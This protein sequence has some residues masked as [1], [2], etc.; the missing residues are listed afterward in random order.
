MGQLR[1]FVSH[2]HG[3]QSF[4]EALVQALRAAGA[5]VWYDQHNLGPGR[6]LRDINREIRDRPIFLVV[7]SQAALASMWVQR[8]EGHQGEEAEQGWGRAGDRAVGPLALSS[9]HP[10]AHAPRGTSPRAASAT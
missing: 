9:P 1:I 6:L 3:D 2:S 10:S 7:L 4:C 5:D 8:K